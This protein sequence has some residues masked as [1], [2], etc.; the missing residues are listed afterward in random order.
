MEHI[1]NLKMTYASSTRMC[2]FVMK[3]VDENATM[4]TPLVRFR[5]FY[6]RFHSEQGLF[7]GSRF[8]PNLTLRFYTCARGP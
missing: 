1:F 8:L 4:K 2:V 3:S 5:Q 6:S 7:H